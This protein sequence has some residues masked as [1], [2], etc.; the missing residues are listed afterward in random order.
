LRALALATALASVGIACKK[1]DDCAKAIDHVAHLSWQ[2]TQKSLPEIA[3]Q[4]R[5]DVAKLM[6]TEEQMLPSLREVISKR[7]GARCREPAFAKCVLA[8][9]D[10]F[11]VARCEHPE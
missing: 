10:S 5:P 3:P 1:Q 6:P 8:A 2:E 11:A 9:P 4:I 7:F